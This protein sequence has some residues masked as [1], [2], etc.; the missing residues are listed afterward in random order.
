MQ[1]RR[2]QA[3]NPADAKF[4]MS[5]GAPMGLMC[6]QCNAGVPA[7]AKFC[8]H[9]GRQLQQPESEPAR[10]RVQQY[11]P[12]ELLAKLESA[13]TSGGA[14]GERRIVTMLFCEV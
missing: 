14:L 10:S 5:C 12:P 3:N 6:P 8:P 1:C 2:C 4:C 13:R 11:V 7:D 9:C